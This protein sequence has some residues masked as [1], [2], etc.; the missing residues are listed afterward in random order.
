M[1][2]AGE[3]AGP[4]RGSRWILYCALKDEQR[5]NSCTQMDWTKATLERLGG[6]VELYVKD[7]EGGHGGFMRPAMHEQALDTAELAVSDAARR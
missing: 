2:N 7:A 3:G 1:L 5:P 6:Q 4:L